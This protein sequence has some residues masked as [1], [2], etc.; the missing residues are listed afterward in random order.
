MKKMMIALVS[1]FLCPGVSVAGGSWG[2][3]AYNKYSGSSGY[4]WKQSS[5]RTAKRVATRRCGKKCEVVTVFRRGC[6]A[7][8]VGRNVG[9]FGYA[10]S[11]NQY[12]A[13]REAKSQ[14]DRFGG[15]FCKIKVSVCNGKHVYRRRYY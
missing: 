10:K 9:V 11:Y 1:I 12:A 5:M 15:K 13:R 7:L 8:A 14:C 2:A 3:V 4:A 6:V